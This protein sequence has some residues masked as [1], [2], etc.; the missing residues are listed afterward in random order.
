MARNGFFGV[1]NSHFAPII[2]EDKLT[3]EKP[4][5]VAGT[6]EISMEPT[7]ESATSHADNDVWL[8]EQQDSGGSGTM[9]FYDTE[10]TPELRKLIA[11]LVGYTIASDGRTIL[12]AN[13]N[14]K[15]FAFFCEQ[16]GHVLGRRRCLLMCQLAKPKQTLTSTQGTPEIT[17]L[18]YPFTWKP[19]IPP[20]GTADDRTSG[21][22]SFTGL[23]DYDTFFEGVNLENLIVSAD[24]PGSGEQ[25]SGGDAPQPGDTGGEVAPENGGE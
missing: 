15:P 17:Q 2:D 22:D 10:S 19:V 1:R 20:G 13:R 16:P 23:P 18:D 21:Y 12:S 7:V 5:H 11:D 9:S 24:S 14:P 25:G 3:Y 4:V 8:E 6:V